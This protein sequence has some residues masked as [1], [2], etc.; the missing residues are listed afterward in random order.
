MI[1][2]RRDATGLKRNEVEDSGGHR[3]SKWVDSGG[4]SGFRL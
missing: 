4:P 2:K 1:E 3:R